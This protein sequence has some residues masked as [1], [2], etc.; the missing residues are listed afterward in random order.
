MTLKHEAQLLDELPMIY[1]SLLLTYAVCETTKRGQK[2]R[3]KVLLPATLVLAGAGVTAGYVSGIY[4][5]HGL[6]AWG[7]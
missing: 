2:K 4:V 3:F 7:E 6:R 1:T 5:R